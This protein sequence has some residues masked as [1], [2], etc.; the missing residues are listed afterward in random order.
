MSNIADKEIETMRRLINF[1]HSDT[2]S[3]V[4]NTPVLEYHMKG[5]DG[6]T[7][8][9]VKECNKFYIKVAPKKDTEPLVEDYDY[10]G[11]INNKKAYEYSSYT[12]AAKQFD[13]KM[14]SLNEAYASSKQPIVEHVK[15]EESDWQINETKEMRS[16]IERFNEITRNV[17]K[18]LGEDTTKGFTTAHTLPEAPAKNPSEKEVNSPYTDTAVAN[19]DKDFKKELTDHEK[20]GSPYDKDGEVTDADMESD[21]AEKGEK[22]EVYTKKAEYV[23]ADSVANQNPSGGKVVRVEAKAHRVK[24][25]EEQVLA[26][27]DSMDYMDKS[28]GTEIGDSAPYTE[29]GCPKNG[30][31]KKSEKKVN[32]SYGNAP[33][34]PEEVLSVIDNLRSN[35]L[36]LSNGDYVY[37]DYDPKSNSMVAGGATNAGIIPE[38]TQE[39]DFNYSFD[40]N[41]QNFLDTIEQNADFHE[42]GFGES[43]SKKEDKKVNEGSCNVM[44]NNDNQNCPTPGNGEIGDG[45]P[46][47][48]NVNEENID[49]NDVAGMPDVPNQTPE[50]DVNINTM[51][52]EDNVEDELPIDV[53]YEFDVDDNT[54]EE[55]KKFLKKYISE[56]IVLN[57]FG[58]HPAYQKA[59]MTTP[60]NKEINQFGNDWN[61]D[62]AKNEKPFGQEIGSSA[63]YDKLV[64]MITDAVMSNFLGDKKKS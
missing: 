63:P 34:T 9:I 18:I 21:K 48:E 51:P 64:K 10:I 25:T 20:A 61:D 37:F 30:E 58:K 11:G 31:C 12:V 60:P 24:L 17:A 22:G 16:E 27:L 42:E 33:Q 19:G 41:L 32:E 23:P 35:I 3:V 5:A 4:N 36:S 54:F 7:Y 52:V 28:K 49:V 59:P 39:Y 29:C 46:Y 50:V 1:S 55:A 6:N 43:C 38:Y 13:L 62:S 14:M 40:E 45:Q 57:D 15:Q 56:N 53:S 2:V 8:G 47:E 44:H 26:W